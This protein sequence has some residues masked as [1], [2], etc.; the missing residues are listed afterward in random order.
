MKNLSSIFTLLFCLSLMTTVEAQKVRG[1]G[2]IVKQE[3]NLS[4]FTGVELSFSGDVFLRQGKT[5]SVYVEGQ[6]NLIDV[7]NTQV[8]DG[9][10]NINFTARNVEMKDKFHIYITLPTL[11][12]AQ[13]SGSGDMSTNGMFTGLHDLRGGVSGSGDLEL[14][15]ECETLSMKISGSGDVEMKGS[16]QAA[17]LSVTGSGTYDGFDMTTKNCEARVTGSGDISTHASETLIASVMGSGDI[18]YKG[19]PRVKA[20]V[21]GSGDVT[22]F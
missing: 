2:P 21:T 3:I 18:E 20:K 1:S 8:K 4:D 16:T 10:W 15:V 6:Q 9:T 5:Q 13:V 19:N 12:Y 11:E 22:G 7:L 17:N 14:E